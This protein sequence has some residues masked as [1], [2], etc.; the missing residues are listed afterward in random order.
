MK[1]NNQKK[2]VDAATEFKK[3]REMGGQG[4]EDNLY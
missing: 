2:N 1:M 3:G 4:D